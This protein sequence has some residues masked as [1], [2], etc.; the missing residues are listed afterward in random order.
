RLTALWDYE[1]YEVPVREGN[2][3]FYLRNSGLQPQPVLYV[4]DLPRFEPRPL[5]DPNTLSKDGTVAVTGTVPSRD[6][7]LLAYG[8][9][10]AGS[11]WQEWRVRK[12]D[13]GED[14]PDRIQWVKFSSAEWTPDGRG[15]YYSRYDAPGPNQLRD[16][17]Y[18]QKLYY[19]RLGTPQSQDRLVYERKDQKEWQFAAVVSDD[20]RW[21][22]VHVSES[23]DPRNRVYVQDLHAK[24]SKVR[25][26]VDV[27]EAKYVFIGSQ[28]SVAWVQTTLPAPRG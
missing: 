17:N 13:T 9:A 24:G 4:V 14:L 20:G 16:V 12:V 1:R 11:D 22:V 21:L 18:F 26:L 7:S 28:G 3:V 19:H 15:F 23:T 6:A 25:P 27:M 8:I 10:E 5:L 2:R